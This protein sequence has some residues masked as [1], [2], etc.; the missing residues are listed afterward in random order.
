M[1]GGL[2]SLF[3]GSIGVEDHP[4][5]YAV[6]Y[7]DDLLFG[8]PLIIKRDRHSLRVK[9]VIPDGD[10]FSHDLLPQLAAH[11]ASAFLKG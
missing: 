5:S 2:C 3:S 6:F 9:T 11:E 1:A 7:Q 4:L 8:H 10:V